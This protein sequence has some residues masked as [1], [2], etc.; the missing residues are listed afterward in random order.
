MSGCRNSAPRS[1]A[2]AGTMALLASHQYSPSLE[3][4]LA[5][6]GTKSIVRAQIC[7][8]RHA[9]NHTAGHGSPPCIPRLSTWL[10]CRYLSV[11]LCSEW[12]SRSCS[13]MTQTVMPQ[14]LM[15]CWMLRLYVTGDGEDAA[16]ECNGFYRASML[17][18]NACR[19]RPSN[20]KKHMISPSQFTR[21]DLAGRFDD[22]FSTALA[23]VWIR[24][25]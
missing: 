19:S 24:S 8:F 15:W 1:C 3:F 21:R 14:L 11:Y 16:R 10:A 6:P 2:P 7:T 23:N 18:P 17:A 20:T 12:V 5:S 9:Y 25:G 13:T 22:K 4:I